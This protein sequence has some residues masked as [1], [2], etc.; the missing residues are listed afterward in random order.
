MLP[1]SVSTKAMMYMRRCNMVFST[2]KNWVTSSRYYS[3]ILQKYYISTHIHA[4]TY[5]NKHTHTLRD[6]H[7]KIFTLP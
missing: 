7:F 4:H 6:E 2:M 5:I 3:G 1:N